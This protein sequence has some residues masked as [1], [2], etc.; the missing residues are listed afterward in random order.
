MPTEK[1]LEEIRRVFRTLYGRR[2]ICCTSHFVQSHC[3]ME[4]LTVAFELIYA[5]ARGDDK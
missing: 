5:L 4:D 1:M 2:W 3:T